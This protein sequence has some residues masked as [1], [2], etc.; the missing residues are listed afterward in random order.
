MSDRAEHYKTALGHFGRQEFAEAI[1][2]YRRALEVSP[3]WTEALHG[4]AMAQM[5]SGQVDEAIETGRRIVELDDHDAFA[6]TSLSLFYQRKS[7]VYEERAN[8][9]KAAGTLT[10]E[11]LEGLKEKARAMIEAAEAE[12]A[13]ARMIAWKEEL[14]T[15]PDAPPPGPAGSMDVI[16]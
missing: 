8:A 2:A 11:E 6:H 14:K 15:N 1:E 10:D 5:Q 7:A 12:G 16:Q 4:L 13:K 9:K 3:D